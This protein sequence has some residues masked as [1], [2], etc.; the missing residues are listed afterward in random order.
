MVAQCDFGDVTVEEREAISQ[1]VAATGESVYHVAWELYGA[2]M[3]RACACA[4]CLSEPPIGSEVVMR[5]LLQ[6]RAPEEVN[7]VQQ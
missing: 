2:A 4:R 1:R 3:G 7:P 5:I 6:G